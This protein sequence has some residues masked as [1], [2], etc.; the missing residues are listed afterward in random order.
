[1]NIMC[2]INHIQGSSLH[3]Q[4]SVFLSLLFLGFRGIFLFL[5]RACCCCFL[6]LQ[7][8]L[9]LLP[10]NFLYFFQQA[11]ATAAVLAFFVVVVC[12]GIFC[13]CFDFGFLTVV[14]LAGARHQDTN[15]NEFHAKVMPT[16]SCVKFKNNNVVLATHNN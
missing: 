6:L 15:K 5:A 11:H 7:W 16:L 9:L 13:C 4:D 8:V 2:H 12:L 1:M 10:F 3:V 14:V